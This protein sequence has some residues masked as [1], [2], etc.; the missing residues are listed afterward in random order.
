MAVVHI[1][2]KGPRQTQNEAL[3]HRHCKTIG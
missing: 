3:K 1:F 2:V